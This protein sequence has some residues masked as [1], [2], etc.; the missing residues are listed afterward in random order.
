VRAGSALLVAVVVA[1]GCSDAA[2]PTFAT[3]PVA[4]GDVVE[5]IAAAARLEPAGRVV[6]S[7][8][9]AGEIVELL[10]ADGDTVRAGDPLLR[11]SSPTLEAQRLQARAAVSATAALA[12]ATGAVG[13]TDLTGAVSGLTDPLASLLPSLIDTLEGGTT[14]ALASAVDAL[15]AQVDQLDALLALA[16]LTDPDDELPATQQLA[17]ALAAAEAA[18]ARADAALDANDDRFD[19]ARDTAGDLVGALGGGLEGLLGGLSAQSAQAAAGQR[20]AV[21][22]QRQQAQLALDQI[23]ER[24]AALF[25]V[26]PSGG[27]VEFA[28]A[29]GGGSGAGL[30]LGALAGIAG[31][32]GGLAGGSSGSTIA[33]G[34]IEL[35]SEVGAGQALLTVYDLAGFTARVE[36]DEI[37]AVRVAVG[38]RAIVLVDAFPDVELVGVVERIAIT[39]TQQ[40]GGGVAYPVTVRITGIPAGITLRVGLTASAEIEVLTVAG[41][42]VVP[43]TALLRRGGSEVVFVVRDGIAVAVPVEV[44]AIGED[45]AAVAGAIEVGETVITTGVES[46]VDGIEVTP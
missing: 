31:D 8:P 20:A 41:D 40:P 34:P 2:A 38:Q 7:A 12:R 15:A 35:G 39:P 1:A 44:L 30:D 26:A 3:A 23:D 22:A 33:S 24:I 43:T 13:A 29:D 5:T 18:L 4:S 42:L 9:A 10:V 37:D 25:V 21:G 6:V 16:R 11:I 45:R 17:A 32:L 27:V 28:S 19:D 36:V 46:A 14:A